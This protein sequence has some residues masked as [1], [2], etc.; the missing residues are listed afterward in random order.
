MSTAGEAGTWI[1]RLAWSTR[2]GWTAR[3]RI[4]GSWTARV[5]RVPVR[6]HLW[7][8]HAWS[9]HAIFSW[10]ISTRPTGIELTQEGLRLSKLSHYTTHAPRIGK[11]SDVSHKS[12]A[13]MTLA[14]AMAPTMPTALSTEVADEVGG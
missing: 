13:T 9:V 3:R 8:R 10:D 7:L 14:T 4:V 6:R 1:G 11:A 2:V 5:G 12:S